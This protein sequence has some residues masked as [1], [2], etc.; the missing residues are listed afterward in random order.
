VL[1]SVKDDRKNKKKYIKESRKKKAAVDAMG[2][3]AARKS[4]EPKKAAAK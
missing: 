4:P 3:L 1:Q 2:I